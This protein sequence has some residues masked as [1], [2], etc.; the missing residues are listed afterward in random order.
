MHG[1]NTML[2]QLQSIL[3]DEKFISSLI[4]SSDEESSQDHILIFLGTDMKQREQILEI[5]AQEQIA[6]GDSSSA[7]K[8]SRIKKANGKYFRIQFEHVF[9]FTVENLA[10]NQVASFILFLNQLIDFPGF[11]LDELEGQTSFR[12]V[13][14]TKQDTTDSFLIANI[15]GIIHAFITFFNQSIERLATGSATF[16]E[17]LEEVVKLKDDFE[18]DS[19]QKKHKNK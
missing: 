2:K 14:L 6:V 15:I 5:T 1:A 16:N 13:W 18:K 19:K 12:Y 3:N 11:Q 7:S 17:L 10:L 8:E 9:P 4:E